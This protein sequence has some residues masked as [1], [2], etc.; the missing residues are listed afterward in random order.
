MPRIR[1][2]AA[3]A[4]LLQLPGALAAQQPASL[5][6]GRFEQELNPRTRIEGLTPAETRE[7]NAAVDR[8]AAIL[9]ANEAVRTP[10]PGICTR[11]LAFVGEFLVGARMRSAPT[12][13]IPVSYDG[14]TCSRISNGAVTVHLNGFGHFLGIAPGSGVEPESE[15]ELR[16]RIFVLPP[17]EAH[18]GAGVRYAQHE[19]L[20]VLTHGRAPLTLPVSR[21]DLLRRRIVEAERTRTEI[22]AMPAEPMVDLERWLREEKPRMQAEFQQSL[23]ELE[24]YLSAEEIQRR[25]EAHESFLAQVEAGM[26]QV[27]APQ[28][29]LDA[30]RDGAAAR[31]QG[32]AQQLRAALDALSPEQRRAPAC[33]DPDNPAAFVGD[34][35]GGGRPY[36]MLNPSYFDDSLPK[37]AV[38]LIVV[39]SP[40]EL[41][42]KEDPRHYELRQRIFQTLDYAALAELLRR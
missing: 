38:Q 30:I 35:H 26:R 17:T 15:R 33:F 22:A 36:V 28:P 6:A 23:R 34:C 14:R 18:A 8:V 3:A 2:F 10:P 42:G 31:T 19:H 4:L 21:E 37:S 32:E 12:V 40:M 7:W 16:E 1:H 25:R 39:S 13:Q 9:R 5:V 29:E 11:L 24:E 27:A 41:R 20:V